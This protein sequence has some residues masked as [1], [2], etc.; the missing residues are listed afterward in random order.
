MF[1]NGPWTA[2]HWEQP[3]EEA[4]ICGGDIDTD[5]WAR[6]FVQGP[7]KVPNSR[8]LAAAPDMYEALGAAKFRMFGAGPSTD[9][10]Y[11]T[12]RDALAK[13]KGE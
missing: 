5:Q 1:T 8:L 11:A 9:P 10:L 12:I 4:E 2:F 3:K 13:A 7:Q 6:I